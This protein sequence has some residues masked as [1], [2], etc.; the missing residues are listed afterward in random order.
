[1]SSPPSFRASRTDCA[2]KSFARARRL[3]LRTLPTPERWASRHASHPRHAVAAIR[4]RRRPTVPP[5]QGRR[6]RA[7]LAARR[8]PGS[9]SSSSS[10]SSGGIKRFS[11]T[12]S[13][14]CQRCGRLPPRRHPRLPLTTCRP[15]R[16]RPRPPRH[17]SNNSRSTLSCWLA[18]RRRRA[19]LRAVKQ[20]S[21]GALSPGMPC[22]RC[23]DSVPACSTSARR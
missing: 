11:L 12:R 17:R 6:H 7:Q 22:G 23:S 10:S 4:P 16:C 13:P 3:L 18:R 21:A 14:L 9:S 5:Q 2:A 8:R 20:R 15:R 1:M 19:R